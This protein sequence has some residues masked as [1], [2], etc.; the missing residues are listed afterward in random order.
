MK[1]DHIDI[2]TGSRDWFNHAVGI[3]KH[4][5]IRINKRFVKDRV[6]CKILKDI[7]TIWN[8]RGNGRNKKGDVKFIESRFEHTVPNAAYS[9]QLEHLC[10]WSLPSS[11]QV[12]SVA[13]IY[14]LDKWF[15]EG[16]IEV[17]G[18][19]SIAATPFGTKLF[20][21]AAGI[22]TSRWLLRTVINVPSFM[23]LAMDGPPKEWKSK[24]FCC[25]PKST[26]VIA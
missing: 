25:I 2:I 23:A 8:V 15:T 21:Y 17:K 26:S 16:H 5:L 10:T 1:K 11:L 9:F 24:L 22:T 6:K 7:E 20:I 3:E 13:C 4:D 18:D 12:S 14:T 19:D